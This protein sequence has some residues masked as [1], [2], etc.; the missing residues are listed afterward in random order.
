MDGGILEGGGGMPLSDTKIRSARAQ[1]KP[2]KIA[3]GEGLFVLVNPIGSKL[4]RLKY[5]YLGKE[6][7]YSIG[8][9]PLVGLAEARE[10]RDNV[11]KT[12]RAGYRS[13]PT[14]PPYQTTKD[15]S[16]AE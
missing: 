11:K 1:T 14:S 6:K 4:W 13:D 16:R 10:T 9:Y 5:R 15:G 8:A 7:L 12:A 2:Y 3:D